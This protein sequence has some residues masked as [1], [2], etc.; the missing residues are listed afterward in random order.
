[1]NKLLVLMGIS[2]LALSYSPEAQAQLFI[3]KDF[4]G[5]QATEYYLAGA[6]PE[7]DGKVC[8]VD[9]VDVPGATQAQ[10]YAGL[11][12]WASFRY[13]P[14][15]ESGEWTD[16]NYFANTEFCTVKEADAEG[17]HIVCAAQEYMVFNNKALAKDYTIINYT[18]TLDIQD[19]RVI[20]T[21]TN[22]VYTYTLAEDYTERIVAEDW[23][24]DAEALNKKGE[25]HRT[26]ARFRIKTVDLAEELFKEVAA[27][28][29]PQ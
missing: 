3:K 9:T 1:M 18:L 20:S 14:S 24:S 2:L 21:L 27:S 4:K 12:Q 7:R 19:E 29:T 28:A 23:I 11:A 6:V 15:V 26:V 13:A 5:R 16:E 25:L 17:G 22:I 10:I 8:F